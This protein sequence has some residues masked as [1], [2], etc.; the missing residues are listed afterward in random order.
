MY[1]VFCVAKQAGKP[2][3]SVCWQFEWGKSSFLHSPDVLLRLQR[4]LCQ[5]HQ[6]Y[7]QVAS[8]QFISVTMHNVDWVSKRCFLRTFLLSIYLLLLTWIFRNKRDRFG[9]RALQKGSKT[10]GFW[11]R[12]HPPQLIFEL[13]MEGTTNIGLETSLHFDRMVSAFLTFPPYCC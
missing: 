4:Q 8:S 3:S 11:A 12:L 1:A 2:P 5:E 7:V 13:W 10:P 9:W 6:N